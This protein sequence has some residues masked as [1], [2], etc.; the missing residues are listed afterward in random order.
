MSDYAAEVYLRHFEA[1]RRRDVLLS[2]SNGQLLPLSK[3]PPTAMVAQ[4]PYIA[5]SIEYHSNQTVPCVRPLA[6][7]V[8]ASYAPNNSKTSL[9]V[10]CA[11]Q[12]GTAH[13]R[14]LQ[15]QLPY[16]ART[17]LLMSQGCRGLFR[18]GRHL[19][20]REGLGVQGPSCLF[21]TAVH[22]AVH[23]ACVFGVPLSQDRVWSSLL[24]TE[25]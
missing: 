18:E 8:E 2:H 19:L 15:I 22:I 17:R 16:S 5:A 1:F 13:G 7:Y 3:E 12:P 24:E 9:L 6:L 25:M 23:I 11:R 20:P 14:N 21:C 4:S 10:I